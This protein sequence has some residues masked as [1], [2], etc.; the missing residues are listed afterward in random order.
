MKIIKISLILCCL[1]ILTGCSNTYDDTSN[2]AIEDTGDKK[3]SIE[4]YVDAYIKLINDYEEEDRSGFAYRYDL[5]DFD[6][7]KIP[8]L[9][10]DAPEGSVTLYTYKNEDIFEI[11]MIPYGRAGRWSVSYSPGNG[12]ITYTDPELRTADG[13]YTSATNYEELNEEGHLER[14]YYYNGSSN[15]EENKYATLSFEDLSGIKTGEEMIVQLQTD[16]ANIEA[17]LKQEKTAP[18]VLLELHTN[19]SG[20]PGPNGENN[21]GISKFL[22]SDG[23]IYEYEYDEYNDRTNY[24]YNDNLELL[25]KNLMTIATKTDTKLSNKDLKIVKQ[26]IHNIE[27]EKEEI[28]IAKNT[29]TPRLSLADDLITENFYMY[30]YVSNTKIQISPDIP[31]ETYYESFSISRLYN[32]VHLYF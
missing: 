2:I 9:L 23:Y 7:D 21:W 31:G 10:V 14:T 15:Q 13:D 30:N 11:G 27:S 22:A 26:Y 1:V 6:G 4:P 12:V 8:E 3:N 29:K 25:S 20:M 17:C 18:K 28:T 24:P 19:H 5:V 32:L 16:S